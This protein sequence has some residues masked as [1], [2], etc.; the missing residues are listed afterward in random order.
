MLTASGAGYSRWRDMAVTR[1][2]EDATRDD[3][4]RSSSCG[5]CRPGRHGHPA[6]RRAGERTAA[7][8]RLRRGPCRVHASGR[9][10][11]DV[12]KSSCRA[13]RTARCVGCH[14]PTADA[15]PATSSDVLCRARALAA[16]RPMRPIRHSP[17]C[18]SRPSI[19]R[20][21]GPDRDAA[22]RSHSEEAVWAAHF[23]V[24]EG[25]WSPI[26]SS[27]PIVPVSS[28]GVGRSRT[29]A[30]LDGDT[31]CRT[32]SGRYWIRSSPAP[33]RPRPAGQVSQGRLLDDGSMVARRAARPRR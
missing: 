7:D 24:V 29:A 18:S 17:R 1:W 12:W 28:G 22:A 5:M 2:R 3:R 19:A 6:G 11:D 9:I 25:E 14:S 20:V 26:R 4:A 32:R 33:T 10:A 8:R 15:G 23:A 30:A 21:R 16:C 27:K 13:S 31:R